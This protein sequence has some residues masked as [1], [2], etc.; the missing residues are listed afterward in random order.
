LQLGQVV[1][2]VGLVQLTGVDQA[3][4]QVANTSAVAGLGEQGVLA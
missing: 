4:E 1:E 3:H 2:R